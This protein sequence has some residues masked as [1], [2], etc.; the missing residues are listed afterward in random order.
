MERK[1]LTKTFIN[2][3]DDLKLEKDYWSSWFIQ[4][5]QRSKNQMLFAFIAVNAHFVSWV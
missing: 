3:Y 5:N 1:E 2:V 4:K